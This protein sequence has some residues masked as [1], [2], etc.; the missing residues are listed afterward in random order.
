MSDDSDMIRIHPAKAAR[1]VMRI[2]SAKAA[3]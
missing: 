1:V 3:E 2:H